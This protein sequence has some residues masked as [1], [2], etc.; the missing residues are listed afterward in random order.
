MFPLSKSK[1]YAYHAWGRD[2]QQSKG[3][4]RSRPGYPGAER[5]QRN[6][7]RGA[8]PFA[9][10]APGA[11]SGSLPCRDCPRPGAR[12]PPAAGRAPAPGP[13]GSP[14]SPPATPASSPRT[15]RPSRGPC[16]GLRSARRGA[17]RAG[18]RP[19]VRFRVPPARGRGPDCVS[20]RSTGWGPD[21]RK[22]SDTCEYCRSAL[23]AGERLL[24]V[25]RHRRGKHFIFE[26]VPARV[27]PR[28]GERY[29]SARL[30]D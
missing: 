3:R 30:W 17:R 29:F 2:Q 26:Q 23:G 4:W 11:S 13:D 25:Y 24:T 28:C 18:A 12:A 9:R 8:A 19:S 7:P 14:R 6:P 27:C 15:R 20:S 22:K 21:M 16:C 10:A 1:R 5:L